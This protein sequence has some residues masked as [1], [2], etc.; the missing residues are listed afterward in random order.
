MEPSILDNAANDIASFN[1]IGLHYEIISKAVHEERNRLAAPFSLEFIRYITAGLISFDMGRLM[2]TAKYSFDRGFASR[3]NDKLQEIRP[4][5]EP[6]TS[7]SLPKADLNGLG[8]NI[9]HSY[10]IL[11]S[12]GDG[13]LDSNPN[14][15]FHVGATKI[16]H[17]LNPELFIIIDS[18]AARVFRKYWNLP[19]RKSTQPGYTPEL[20]LE[21]MKKVQSEIIGYGVEEFRNLEL[22]TPVTRIFDKVTFVIGSMLK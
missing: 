2:G 22:D 16:L 12:R 9:K 11:A 15:A 13:A 4:L 5:V 14:K 7:L 8:D 3:L 19:F 18:N 20:Y 21:C 10:R 6:L 17:F 1:E